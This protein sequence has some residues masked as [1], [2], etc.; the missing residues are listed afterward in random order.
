MLNKNQ[1]SVPS[2]THPDTTGIPEDQL[3]ATVDIEFKEGAI[4]SEVR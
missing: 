3:Q 2:F 1:H 4:G